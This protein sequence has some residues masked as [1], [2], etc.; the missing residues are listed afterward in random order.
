MALKL[1]DLQPIKLSRPVGISAAA[2]CRLAR[3]RARFGQLCVACL[4][5]ARR[6]YLGRGCEFSAAEHGRKDRRAAG[7]AA[8][9]R[10]DLAARSGREQLFRR[11]RQ[12]DERGPGLCR[13]T[14]HARKFRCLFACRA[15]RVNQGRTGPNGREGNT[16]TWLLHWLCSVC[17]C[18]PSP[19]KCASG[20][21]PYTPHLQPR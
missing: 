15:G 2:R 4:S 21:T 19:T 11:V 10:K 13:A 3:S 6:Y 16:Q 17:S 5:L 7:A 1:N 20:N 14:N 9:A 12:V 18:H 8:G